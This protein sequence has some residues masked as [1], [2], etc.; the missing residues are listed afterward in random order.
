MGHI[1]VQGASLLQASAAQAQKQISGFIPGCQGNRGVATIAL[2]N[3]PQSL[4]EASTCT[5]G[6]SKLVKDCALL[7]LDLSFVLYIPVQRLDCFLKQLGHL[8]KS[9]FEIQSA[10]E[11]YVLEIPL[12]SQKLLCSGVG[13]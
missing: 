2:S 6:K 3:N 11:G 8:Y 9:T 5:A 10:F 13:L 4:Q 12:V 1:Y 7:I